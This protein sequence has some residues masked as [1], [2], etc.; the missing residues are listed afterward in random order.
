MLLNI[1]DAIAPFSSAWNGFQPAMM[2]RAQRYAAIQERLIGP[3]G[4]FPPIGRSLCYRFGAFH[5]LA[6]MVLRRKLPEGVAPEQVR[7]G[8]TTVMRRMMQAP[9]TF[10]ERGWLRVG[11]Y[12]HQ[13]SIAESYISTGSCYL[14]SAAWLPLGLAAADAFW[15]NPPLPWTSKKTWSGEQVSADHAL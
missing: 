8:L 10:D 9:G 5:L 14:C 3:E 12:G 11:F 1:L 6:E 7:S 13:P 2:V 15:S 4:T